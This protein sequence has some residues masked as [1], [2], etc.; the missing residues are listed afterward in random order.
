MIPNLDNA[1]YTF[2][3]TNLFGEKLTDTVI[4]SKPTAYRQTI[5]IDE[6][7]NRNGS[8]RGFTD[9]LKNN[10]YFTIHTASK[11]N[12]QSSIIKLLRKGNDYYFSRA[13][14]AALKPFKLTPAQLTEFI[15]F[16]LAVFS[17]AAGNTGNPEFTMYI[18]RYKKKELKFIF[19]GES[20]E[21]LTKL[22]DD[23]YGKKKQ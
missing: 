17:N 4:I 22:F 16:Q 12:S 6:F 13:D 5:C 15:H 1:L 14:S 7:R 8:S 18:F 19:D 21:W 10:E 20:R 9:Y 11:K 23:F 2:S 3:Y